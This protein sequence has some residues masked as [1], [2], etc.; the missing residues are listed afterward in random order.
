[1]ADGLLFIIRL[2]IEFLHDFFVEALINVSPT[3]IIIKPFFLN[4]LYGVVNFI[5]TLYNVF[6]NNISQKGRSSMKKFLT[7]TDKK[8]EE[9][10]SKHS[11][12]ALSSSIH[13]LADEIGV[14][15][16]SI[17]KYIK[18]IGFRSY[19]RFKVNLAQQNS[20]SIDEQIDKDDS[21]KTIQSK[22]IK[23][24]TRSYEMTVELID[25]D[26]LDRVINLIKNANRIYTFGVG[27]SGMVCNDIYFKLSRIGKNIVYHTDSHIQLASLSNATEKD[28]V[29]GVSYSA[30]TREVFTAFEI[31]KQRGIPTVSI[32]GQ[33]NGNLDALSTYCLKVP[34]HEK[35][36]RSA[37]IT[38]RN[39]SLF[40]VDLLYL[41]LLQKDESRANDIIE[42]SY[43]LTH[44]LRK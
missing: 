35:S 10:I 43:N 29:I 2:L 16:S 4:T 36:I 42:S 1:M 12:V 23:T 33:G 27:A 24:I 30:N 11:D 40:L 7:A 21:I 31:A 39:D 37:A 13:V 34:R 9:F 17:S 26:T 6:G 8:I 41:G 28:L 19:S 44:Q 22:L 14:S 32:T 20:Q 18:K 3:K 15:S 25:D 38:S 5:S